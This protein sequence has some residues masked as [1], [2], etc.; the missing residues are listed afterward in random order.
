[1]KKTKKIFFYFILLLVLGWVVR[2]FFYE[3]FK[4]PSKSM[5]PTLLKGDYVFVSKIAYGI[6]A[7]FS[8]KWVLKFKSPKRGDVIVFKHTADSRYYIK[9]IMG[10]PGD[11]VSTKGGLLSVNNQSLRS[12]NI[13]VLKSSP[14]DRCVAAVSADSNIPKELLPVPYFRGHKKYQIQTET[15]LN[16][17]PHYIQREKK[18]SQGIEFEVK[19]PENSYFVMGDNRDKAV[20]SRVWGV[21]SHN[22]VVG[23]AG[24]VWL[25]LVSDSLKCKSPFSKDS[26]SSTIRWYRLWRDVI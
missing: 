25:S 6:K 14:N 1:M 16:S 4:I 15:V 17:N 9:R 20:D 26:K 8:S 12:Q 3:P 23:K 24:T 19:V 11:V 22:S 7:P 18:G 13:N 21:V 5:L 10:L 2:A